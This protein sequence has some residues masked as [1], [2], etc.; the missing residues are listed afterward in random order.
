MMSR[1]RN[2]LCTKIWSF[3]LFSMMI[4]FEVKTFQNQKYQQ[5]ATTE[6]KPRRNLGVLSGWKFLSF[7]QNKLFFL[8][9]FETNLI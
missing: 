3:F 1:D 2:M 8:T 5:L 9:T 4:L 6:K 7:L